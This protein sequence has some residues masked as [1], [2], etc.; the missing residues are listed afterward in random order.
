MGTPYPF[1]ML[2][3]QRVGYEAQVETSSETAGQKEELDGRIGEVWLVDLFV[4]DEEFFPEKGVL[5]VGY[6]FDVREV[7][8]RRERITR[9]LGK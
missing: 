2:P 3:P 6:G 4:E 7:C 9:R 5:G 1:A 8:C